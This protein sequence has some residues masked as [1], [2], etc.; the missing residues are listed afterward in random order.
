MLSGSSGGSLQ[1]TVRIAAPP[2]AGRHIALL[3]G[4]LHLWAASGFE[5]LA[6]DHL[7]QTVGKPRT[8][9]LASGLE[10]AVE[11]QKPRGQEVTVTLGMLRHDRPV[12]EWN[13]LERR[14]RS[15][16]LTAIDFTEH[17]SEIE[18]SGESWGPN[19]HWIHFPTKLPAP[20]RVIARIPTQ[21]EIQ[22]PFSLHDLPLP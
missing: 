11:L 7:D 19:E 20:V 6:A 4:A 13:M 14:L 9:K 5:E 18:H 17:Q 8:V 15:T 12:N 22:I 16:R 10:I 2:N 3:E 21:T 1:W